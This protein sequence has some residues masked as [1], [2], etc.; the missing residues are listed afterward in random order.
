MSRRVL[1]LAVAGLL[2]V[3]LAAVSALLPVPYVALKP[4]PTTNTLGA[5]GGTELIRI[6]GRQTYP[7][8]G[9]LD[10]VTVSVEGGPGRKM[11]LF[12]AIAGWLDD[13]VA[14]VPEETV[15]PAGETAEQA[16]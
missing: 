6:D 5:V 4:G 16:E 3:L 9:H 12:T 2:T 13:K 15:Y 8:K 7:D 1:V 14:V 11:D 10:L